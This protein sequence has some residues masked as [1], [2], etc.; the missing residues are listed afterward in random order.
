LAEE[1]YEKPEGKQVFEEK[2]EKDMCPEINTKYRNLNAI[3]TV[4]K[5]C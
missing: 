4:N 3:F 1:N 2:S 5:T